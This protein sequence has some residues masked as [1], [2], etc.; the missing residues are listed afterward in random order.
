MSSLDSGESR[1]YFP[2]L[3]GLSSLF[4]LKKLG[5]QKTMPSATEPFCSKGC[6]ESVTHA[7]VT[8]THFSLLQFLFHFKPAFRQNANICHNQLQAHAE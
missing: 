7:Q 8:M 1:L 3:F 5:F 6:L 2:L 4:S